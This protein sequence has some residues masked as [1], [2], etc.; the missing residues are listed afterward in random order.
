LLLLPAGGETVTTVGLPRLPSGGLTGVGVSRDGSR[1][2]LVVGRGASARLVVGA[3]TGV[4]RIQA[5]R[6]EPDTVSVVGEYEVLPDLRG[7]RD[8]AWADAVTL[9]TL[10][11]DAGLPLRVLDVTVDG[12]DVGAI[13]PD[14]D[15]V[16]VASAPAQRADSLLVVGTA[17]G[18]LEGYT[19]GRG[20]VELGPGSDP[21]YPG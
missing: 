15:V 1:V 9:T 14:S 18:R 21:A 7:V 20:W 2:A 10:G 19:S 3:V 17:D 12:F 16:T 4:D 13:E 8:V 11:R 6:P 5:Q